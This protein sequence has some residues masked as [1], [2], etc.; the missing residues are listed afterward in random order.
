MARFKP[1]LVN[2][3]EICRHLQL[4]YYS[5]FVLFLCRLLK[6]FFFRINNQLGHDPH[7]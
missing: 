4:K 2:A 7:Y 3:H 1:F 5:A 6:L